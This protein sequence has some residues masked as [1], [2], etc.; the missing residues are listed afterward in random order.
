MF[1]VTITGSRAPTDEQIEQAEKLIDAFSGGNMAGGLADFGR[2]GSLGG[3]FGMG[4][5]GGME[6]ME[7]LEEM[8]KGLGDLM[9]NMK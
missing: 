4:G 2:M 6:G 3:S 8:M 1:P 9:K 7:N 5:M